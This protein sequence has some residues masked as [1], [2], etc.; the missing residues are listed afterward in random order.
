MKEGGQ[1]SVRWTVNSPAMRKVPLSLLCY[2]FQKD[3]NATSRFRN[4]TLLVSSRYF[5]LFNLFIFYSLKDFLKDVQHSAGAAFAKYLKKIL[6]VGF[7]QTSRE[8]S[9]LPTGTASGCRCMVPSVSGY[10]CW[11]C[12]I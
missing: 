7:Q 10:L 4:Q 6:L 9:P 11:L 1:C 8:T 2:P 12:Y 3:C 5:H